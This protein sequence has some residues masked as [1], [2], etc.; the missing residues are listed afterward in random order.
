MQ[1][2]L[3]ADDYARLFISQD[4]IF[5]KLDFVNDV[6]YYVGEPVSFFFGKID[7]PVNI[8][9]NKLPAIIGR[10][11]PKDNFDMI[12]LALNYSFNWNEIFDFA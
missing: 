11:E 9:T 1:R 12:H 7:Q 8:L 4:N 5:L 6:S 3:F 10:D 2:S